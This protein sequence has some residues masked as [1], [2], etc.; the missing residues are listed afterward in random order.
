MQ[1][2]S[3][4][5]TGNA[6]AATAIAAAVLVACLVASLSVA[7]AGSPDRAHQEA[8]PRA[9]QPK[10]AGFVTGRR[11]ELRPTV[12]IASRSGAETRSVLSLNLPRLQ[13]GERV[14]FNGEVTITT[15]CVEQI[16]RC[17]GQ[18]YDF[19]PRLRARIVIAPDRDAAGRATRPVSKAVGL[20]CEQTRPNR[21]HHCPLVVEGGSFSVGELRDL[22]CRPAR[23]RLNMV[24]D[25]FHPSAGSD[26]FV[27]IGSDQPDGSVEGGK[28]RL[29]AVVSSGRMSIDERSTKGR[30]ST[31]LPASFSGGKSVVYSQKLENLAAG[32]VLLVR[33]TQRTA[34][35]G[36]PYFISD[37]IVISTRRNGTRPS[38]LSRR[39]VSRSGLATET[40]GFNCTLGP[41][42]FQSPCRGV[43]AG[44]A[45]IERAPTDKRGHPKPLF[46]NL[47]SRGFP[48][49][50]QA[51]GSFPPA[52]IVGGGRLIVRRLRA[53]SGGGGGSGDQGG[54]KR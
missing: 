40:T 36:L 9:K 3:A 46:V 4:R 2:L 6:R 35:Q 17:I 21:N 8:S 30:V 44:M 34:I 48:K 11:A 25:A 10:V 53:A 52:E 24:L 39:I 18:T 50:A 47:V 7:A 26:Q 20:S 43:K 51:R 12:P 16:G 23:C 14:R 41:S 49:L 32:D 42:A 33:S 28:A 15:T 19:D 27:V 29:S 54:G 38:R 1:G 37:Q 22:P 13:R 5:F 31:R 45:V